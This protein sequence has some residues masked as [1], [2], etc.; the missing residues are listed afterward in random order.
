[1]G[2]L[3]NREPFKSRNQRLYEI[4]CGPEY[5]AVD[6]FVVA[7]VMLILMGSGLTLC[8]CILLLEDDIVSIPFMTKNLGEK[9]NQIETRMNDFSSFCCSLLIFC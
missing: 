2:M 3:D 7:G 5:R 9:E 6:S 8:G 1:M 4:F